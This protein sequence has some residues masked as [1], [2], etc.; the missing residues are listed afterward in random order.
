MKRLKAG[1]LRQMVE[2]QRLT[3]ARN[4]DGETVETWTKYARVPASVEPLSVRERLSADQM[5]SAVTVKVL[6]R[7]RLITASDR[8]VYRGN[9][10]DILGVMEDHMS[11]A[12]WVTLMAKV[13]E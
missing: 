7:Y 1:R 8:M 13:S 10:Y 2:L 9:N 3:T 11:G 5:D 12:E 6:L 4:S